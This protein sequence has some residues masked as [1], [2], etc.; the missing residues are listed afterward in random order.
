MNDVK[1]ANNLYSIKQMRCN[2]TVAVTFVSKPFLMEIV[3]FLSVTLK[4]P[5]IFV[6]VLYEEEKTFYS[7]EFERTD[8]IFSTATSTQ[9]FDEE[10]MV[11][12]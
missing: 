7:R 9:R 5:S 11:L 10:V 12:I 3:L 2:S 4:F 6:N 8:S 1:Q